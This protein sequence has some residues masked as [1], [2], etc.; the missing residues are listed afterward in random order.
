MLD[1]SVTDSIWIICFV[2]LTDGDANLLKAAFFGK[3]LASW[4]NSFCPSSLCVGDLVTARACS[5]KFWPGSKSL[6]FCIYSWMASIILAWDLFSPACASTSFLIVVYS[7]S[8]VLFK[9]PDSFVE[10]WRVPDF[11]SLKALVYPSEVRSSI[12]DYDIFC[13]VSTPFKHGSC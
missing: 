13:L 8:D 11:L 1:L 3:I 5:S 6:L 12:L 9:A 4:S 10:F 7:S 2:S